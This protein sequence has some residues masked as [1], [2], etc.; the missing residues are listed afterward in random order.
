MLVGTLI[1]P[2]A[3]NL[4]GAPSF[5]APWPSMELGRC[6]LASQAERGGL[7]A[8]KAKWVECQAICPISNLSQSWK[9]SHCPPGPGLLCLVTLITKNRHAGKQSN[10]HF[11]KLISRLLSLCSLLV[12][13]RPQA[14]QQGAP[15][16]PEG[17][18]CN[19]PCTAAQEWLVLT[20]MQPL[21]ASSCSPAPERNT[22]EG[23]SHNHPCTV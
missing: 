7:Q 15:H 11:G 10:T 16:A 4:R 19:H 2:I 6:L 21:H 12:A 13:A 18:S 22:P 8:Q 20:A 14:P 3:P 1:A 5:V 23:G 9:L 17:C